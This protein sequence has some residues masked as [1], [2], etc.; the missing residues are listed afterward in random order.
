MTTQLSALL[1]TLAPV[2][3]LLVLG[4]VIRTRG[5]QGFVHGLGDWN[6][7]DEKTRRRAGRSTGNVLYAMAALLAGH[8]YYI[9]RYINDPPRM[10]LAA[11]MFSI[12]MAVLIIGLILHLLHLQKS[13]RTDRH[14]R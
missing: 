5:P 11:P 6:N 12:G 10:R 2:A 8:G 7:V 1:S 4:Y 9:Y 3:V 13:S 14:D